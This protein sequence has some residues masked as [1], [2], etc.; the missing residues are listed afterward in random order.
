MESIGDLIGEHATLEKD[1]N[2]FYDKL[3]ED[4]KKCTEKKMRDAMNF[5]RDY[6]TYIN[7][8]NGLL[9]VLK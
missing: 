9:V 7:R 2:S 6:H 3:L 8:L 4:T 5:V 1:L